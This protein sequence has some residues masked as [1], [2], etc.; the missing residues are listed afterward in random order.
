MNLSIVEKVTQSQLKKDVPDLRT[1]AEVRVHVRIKE[2]DKSRIQVFEGVII[3][4]KGH[5]VAENFTVRKV[6]GGIGVQR[7][8]PIHSPVIE[9]IEVLRYGKVRR[10]KLNYLRGRSGKKSRIVESKK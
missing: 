10:S 3:G 7:I 9:K 5:G 1:G 2:G 4:I 6:S 8:F